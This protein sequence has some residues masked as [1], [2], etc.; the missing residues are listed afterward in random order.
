M[1]ERQ[2]EAVPAAIQ[3]HEGMLLMPQHF[4]QLGARGE[5]LVAHGLAFATQHPWGVTRLKID[6]S[7]L[8]NG[9]FRID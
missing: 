2:L 9:V 3:W 4:Q 5:A 8:L 1:T 6:R 7:R